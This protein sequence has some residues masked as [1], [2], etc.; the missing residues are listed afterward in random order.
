MNGLEL[1]KA[2]REK[3]ERTRFIILTGYDEFEYARKAI[4][5]DVENYILKPIDEEELAN[6][7]QKTL[8]KLKKIDGS[9]SLHLEE[10]THWMQFLSGKLSK[11]EVEKYLEILKLS[12]IESSATVAIMKLDPSRVQM[13]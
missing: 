5:L 8:Q 11:E 7:L 6:Q 3:D 4:R 9:K 2:I 10:Q 13:R 12:V 1:L